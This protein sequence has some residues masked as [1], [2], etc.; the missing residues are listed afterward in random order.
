MQPLFAL[1][2]AA[3]LLTAASVTQASNAKYVTCDRC[4]IDQTNAAAVSAGAN[5]VYVMDRHR[6]QIKHFTIERIREPG[7][8]EVIAIQLPVERS[9]LLTFEQ[10]MDQYAWEKSGGVLEVPDHLRTA[11]DFATDTRMHDS[12]TQWAVL[13]LRG[14]FGTGSA[15]AA[16]VSQLFGSYGSGK[17][18]FADGSTYEFRFYFTI[19]F[20]LSSIK[21]DLRP[22]RGSGRSGGE[23]V[24]ESVGGFTGVYARDPHFG[25]TIGSW[26][27]AADRY[28]IPT[29]VID[30]GTGESRFSCQ[31]VSGRLECTVTIGRP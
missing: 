8:F 26:M 22:I 28:G 13:Q 18:R 17:L 30:R 6:R 15:V 3:L 19:T 2:G 10:L 24:P 16:M 29:T 25:A 4:S 12:V 9:V 23:R 1:A 20:D 21:I 11:V 14:R 27:R 5:D 31:E 7:Y